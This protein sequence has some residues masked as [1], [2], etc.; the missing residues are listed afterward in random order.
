MTWANES[1]PAANRAAITK[2]LV[3]ATS[4]NDSTVPADV[5]TMSNAEWISYSDAWCNGWSAGIDEG[6]RRERE[7]IATIGREAARIVHA[8]AEI[9]PRD[10]DAD[11]AAAARRDARWSA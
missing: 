5:T 9:P 10:A 2:H 3:G 1:R 6:R 8:M 7:E 4:E 11:R